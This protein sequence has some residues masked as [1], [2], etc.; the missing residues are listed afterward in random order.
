MIE[1]SDPTGVQ[2]AVRTPL[3]S[4]FLCMLVACGTD[5]GIAQQE[6][7]ACAVPVEFERYVNA[8][9]SDSTDLFRGAYPPATALSCAL[10]E[11]LQEA[12]VDDSVRTCF[13]RLSRRYWSEDPGA[14][15]TFMYIHHHNSFPLA[16]AATA[17]W[18][19]DHRIHG[20]RALETYR[21]MRPMVCTTEAGYVKLQAQDSA[22]VRY[23]LRVLETTP[24]VIPGSENSTIHGVYMLEVMRALDLFT[25]RAHMIDHENAM[26]VRSSE[27]EVRAYMADWRKWLGP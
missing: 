11:I 16:I 10:L 24:H 3:L 12:L 17:H 14:G 8:T 20:L 1:P 7:R 6:D 19:E 2:G 25:D 4:I 13:E 18:N 9:L 22:T 26:S 21:L 5:T 15:M 23:L 27:A